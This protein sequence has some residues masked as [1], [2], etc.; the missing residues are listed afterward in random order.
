MAQLLDSLH[1][2]FAAARAVTMALAGL[3]TGGCEGLLPFRPLVAQGGDDAVAVNAT[4]VAVMGFQARLRAGG[5]LEN[6]PRAPVV[7]GPDDLLLH[8]AAAG[9]AAPAQAIAGA[10]LVADGMPLTVAMTKGLELLHLI[11]VAAAA[12]IHP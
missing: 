5:L 1:V 10:G 3:R 9:T 6:H 8:I 2:V 4:V 12:V 11:L 7:A